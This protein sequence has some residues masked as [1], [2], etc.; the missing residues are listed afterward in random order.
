MAQVLCIGEKL[1]GFHSEKRSWSSE[2]CFILSM[3]YVLLV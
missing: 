1:D 2:V 3:C